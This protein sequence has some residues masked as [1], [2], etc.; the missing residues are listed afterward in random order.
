[1]L[2]LLLALS[3]SQAPLAQD[4][5]PPPMTSADVALTHSARLVSKQPRV[6]TGALIG[7]MATTTV[8]GL[9]G[10]ALGAGLAGG[11]T[12]LG[13][14]AGSYDGV[15]FGIG[16]FALA[17]PIAVGLGI[18]GVAIGAAFFGNDFGKDFGE[19]MAVAGLSVPIATACAFLLILLSVTPVLAIAVP[20]LAATI[21]TPLIVQARKETPRPERLA[22]PL[23]D[24]VPTN[25][26]VF[27][28]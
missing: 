1:M 11:A 18:L 12:Y 17:L 13:L 15:I 9:L 8:F 23:K 28:L 22:P 21:A 20:F 5:T 25:G 7:K 3:V 6:S 27:Q 19:A 14:S 4:F 2:T 16:A 26:M 10:S 24:E